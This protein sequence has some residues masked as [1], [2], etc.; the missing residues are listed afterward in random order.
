MA[1]MKKRRGGGGQ[2]P[3]SEDMASEVRDVLSQPIEDSSRIDPNKVISTGST[4]LNLALTDFNGGYVL[5]TVVHLIGDT[6]VGKSLLALTMMAEA[7][8][9]DRFKDYNLIY[10]E[11]EA[12][13]MFPLEKMFGE[14][15]GRVK[16]IPEDRTEPRTVQ[17]WHRDLFNTYNPVKKPYLY[18]TD[19][20]DALS[21]QDQV[22]DTEP[23][24]G[25]YKTE[26]ALVASE[27]FPKIVGRIEK[28]KSLYIWI[29]QTRENIGVTFGP[30]KTFSG[31]SA[32]K[33]YRSFEIWLA[34]EGQITK[35]VR[36]KK[37]VVGANV[38]VLVKK[39]KFTGKVREVKFPVYYEYGIDD[40]G[41][42]V[43][44][45]V[46]EK[47]WGKRE[48]TILTEGDFIDATRPKLIEYIEEGSLEP[49]LKEIVADCWGELEKEIKIDR[50]RRY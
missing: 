20:F 16:F 45:M 26:K 32:I 6:N 1:E 7:S 9:D 12:A 10:E 8:K 3:T 15:I 37:R 42:M 13:M 48:Q 49:G 34:H 44:W 40:V 24:K 30:K 39:N 11:P 18:V 25:G 50:K 23:T 21:S 17:D 47:F 41:S 43:D 35:V 33:F 29:S 46:D 27:A 14:G 19:S 5:G 4:L 31:G 2:T 36:G 22:G 28:T 38:K